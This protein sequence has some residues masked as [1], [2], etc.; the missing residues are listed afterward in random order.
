MSG[1]AQV[2]EA[3][4]A[5]TDRPRSG[6]ELSRELGVSRAQVWKHVETL[7]A[8]GYGI[9]GAPGG[10]YRLTAV[11][12]RLYAEELAAGLE[13]QWLGHSIHHYETIDSTNR[14]AGELAR[15]GARHGTAVVAEHQ[16]AGRGR[17]GRSFFSPAHQNLYL[18]LVLRPRLLVAEAPPLI[19][20]A[21]L[22]VARCVADRLG[23]PGRVD[24]KW[25]NDVQID[26]RK[27]SG[28]LME[29]AAEATEVRHL[30][31]GIGVNLNV[32][33]AAFPEEFRARATSLRA[34][35]GAP[36]DRVDFTRRLFF[37]LEAVLDRHAAGGFEALRPDF[38][39]FYR[40]EGREIEVTGPN[41]RGRRG[42][43]GRVGADGAL[44]FH[45]EDG[46]LE[47]VIAGDV[48]LRAGGV[49]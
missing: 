28:I 30:V 36:L 9:E 10:G 18:S 22:A 6:E 15:E 5:A 21:A 23:E 17:L 43:A 1:P 49:P 11:P 37:T 48:T 40:M 14:V 33:P 39:G 7:R 42:R 35:L 20:G 24:I 4:R 34:A 13:T 16:S 29:M 45:H 31:L 27:V 25:P 12:D 44:E 41:G 2:L 3:L 46:R 32:D 26:G 38:E 19:L 8:R 47:R